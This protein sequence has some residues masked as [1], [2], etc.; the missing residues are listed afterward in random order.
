MERPADRIRFTA[1]HELGHVL[2]DF[3]AAESPEGDCH[4]FGAAFLLPRAALE[5][6]FTPSRRKVTLGRPGRDQG[7]LRRVAS[8]HHVPG[9]RAGTHRATGSSGR[10]AKRSRPRTGRSRSRWRTRAKNRRRGSAGSFTTP[11]PRTSSTWPGPR[12]WP[13]S[14]PVSS[15]K[16]SETSFDH[17][18]QGRGRSMMG[19]ASNP[20]TASGEGSWR[21]PA[22]AV[23]PE[24]GAFLS[25][26]QK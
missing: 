9:P 8:G 1:A 10:S 2:C 16:R 20:V 23:P 22:V 7:D 11:S 6:A 13:A 18:R 5:K 21:P 24:A 25:E 14:R 3:E 15:R 4:A 26:N 19:H 12:R 17:K